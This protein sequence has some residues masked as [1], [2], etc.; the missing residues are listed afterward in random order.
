MPRTFDSPMADSNSSI[1]A[2]VS[3]KK[4]KDMQDKTKDGVT[5]VLKRT[6]LGDVTKAEKK[7]KELTLVSEL[8]HTL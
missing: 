1:S 6:E 4:R 3:S 8:T 5:K 2:A 7:L